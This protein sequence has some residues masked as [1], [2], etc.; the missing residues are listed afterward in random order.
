MS[1][2]TII[3]AL[4]I[5][6]RALRTI[7]ARYRS[8]ILVVG[9]GP[10]CAERLFTSH[11]P[12]A[13]LLAGVAG[14][15]VDD[16]PART[17]RVID[18]HTGD[19]FTPDIA[20]DP[21]GATVVTTHAPACTPTDKATLARTHA[22]HLVDTE[23]AH[24]A[25]ACIER[26]VPWGV[27]RAVSDGPR[28]TLPPEVARWT[29]NTGDTRVARVLLDTIK[30]PSLARDLKRLQASTSTALRTLAGRVEECLDER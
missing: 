13:V 9:P 18:A 30:R 5:E 15:L 3:T 14:G 20:H 28:D 22:A 4:S 11:T 24:I 25:R 21:D 10:A 27:L 23:S 7:A 16:P 19:R 12:Q 8:R 6:A 1:T 29:T 17:A 26:A 2:P